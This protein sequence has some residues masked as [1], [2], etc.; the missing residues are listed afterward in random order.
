M[1]ITYMNH[2]PG[3]NKWKIGTIGFFRGLFSPLPFMVLK[4]DPLYIHPG[5]TILIHKI[6]EKSTL[7]LV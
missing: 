6:V 4:G 2:A 3:E 7:T 5:S 1:G